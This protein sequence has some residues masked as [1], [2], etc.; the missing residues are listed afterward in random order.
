MFLMS[1]TVAVINGRI[2][3][4]CLALVSFFSSFVFRVVRAEEKRAFLCTCFVAFL[5]RSFGH[6]GGLSWV[7]NKSGRT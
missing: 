3:P 5:V 7:R 2:G 1:G 4:G 6:G